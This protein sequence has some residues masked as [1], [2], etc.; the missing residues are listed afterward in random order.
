MACPHAA[1]VA[2]LLLHKNPTLS[3]DDIDRILQQT[4][5]DAGAPGRDNQHGSGRIDALAAIQAVPSSQ[6]PGLVVEGVQLIDAGG[7]GYF[8]AGETFAL[9]VGV[10]NN[11]RL[12]DAH[13]VTLSLTCSD[14][15]V[16][17]IDGSAAYGSVPMG[18]VVDNGT[19]ELRL[20]VA[21]GTPRGTRLDLL[22]QL[23]AAGGF[24][25]TIDHRVTVGR[26][27]LQTHTTGRVALSVTDRGTLGFWDLNQVEGVGFGEVGGLN[28]LYIGGLWAGTG[29]D[30][31]CNRDYVSV[32]PSE[33]IVSEIPNGRLAI[34]TIQLADQDYLAYFNDAGHAYPRGIQI[35]QHS[36]SWNEPGY[37]GF[38]M[39][40]YEIFNA[41]SETVQ[42]YHAGIFCDFDILYPL[43]NNAAV[44]P[45]LNLAYAWDIDGNYYGIALLSPATPASLAVIPNALWSTVESGF[46]DADKWGFLSGAIGPQDGSPEADYSCLVS[47]GPF[48]LP[49]TRTVDVAFALVYGDDLIELRANAAAAHAKYAQTPTA[50][51]RVAAPAAL[52][53]EQNIPNPFNPA[54]SIA[55]QLPTDGVTRLEVLDIRGRRVR[56]LLEGTLSSGRH[57]VRWDGTDDAG[58][59]AASGTY[60]YRLTTEQGLKTR[61]MVLLE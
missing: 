55:F 12:V 11:S 33:W 42:G 46:T 35:R 53:L 13:E 56:G 59:S 5:V 31:V 20:Q 18:A 51:P 27:E 38:V 36:M 50:G 32:D 6:H 34:P 45:A 54:T 37:D 7:D 30:Y 9:Q 26:P 14:P 22:L 16:T 25:R 3:P 8:E 61:K 10:L 29:P 43:I 2:A 1:G 57:V 58:R 40:R 52:A 17:V 39:L 24:A 4:A 47:A 49:R 60:F 41:G 19:D 21:L 44:D 48:D 28:G 23:T 15:R